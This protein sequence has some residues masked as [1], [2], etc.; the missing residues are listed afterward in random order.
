MIDMEDFSWENWYYPLGEKKKAGVGV[1]CERT[2]CGGNA[3]HWRGR[4]WAGCCELLFR[5]CHQLCA[6]ISLSLVAWGQWGLCLL[7]G[8]A[9]GWEQGPGLSSTGPAWWGWAAGRTRDC[10]MWLS[11]GAW[12]VPGG[13]RRREPPHWHE[14]VP[15]LLQAEETWISTEASGDFCLQLE[16]RGGHAP[17]WADAH[18][19]PNTFP[20]RLQSYLSPN[21]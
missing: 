8:V 14:E 11:K 17:V 16:T 5:T 4:E 19:G 13:T 1:E 12:A 20:L 7:S 3:E 18:W 6:Y 9:Q 10:P 2:S 21:I 15:G